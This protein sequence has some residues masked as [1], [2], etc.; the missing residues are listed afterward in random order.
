MDSRLGFGWLGFKMCSGYTVL[1]NETF[2]E[3][4][5]RI[6]LLCMH[7]DTCCIHTLRAQ[8]P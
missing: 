4:E 8:V 5:V 2:P 6:C 7:I 3:K 1:L